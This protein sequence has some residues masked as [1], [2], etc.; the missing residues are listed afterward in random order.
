MTQEYWLPVVG[1]EGLYEVSDQGRVRSL[2]RLRA[3]GGVTKERLLRLAMSGPYL[4]V[5][6]YVGGK[7]TGA[8]VHQ[9]VAEAF[10]GPCPEGLIVLHGTG[11]KT[12]NRPENLSYGTY[13]KNNGED[14]RRDGTIPAGESHHK[15]TLTA[16]DV[17]EIRALRGK[18]T[19][20]EIGARYGLAQTSIGLIQRRL[21]W[22]HLE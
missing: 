4:N 11:G 20:K 10:I 12:D 14:R 16:D 18:I 13:S 9:L 3:N 1:Y 15:T 21:R 2:P 8:R 7:R 22:A 5:S 6:L 17:R 19:Q